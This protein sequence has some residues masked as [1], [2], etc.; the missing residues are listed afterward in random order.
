[1]QSVKYRI[2]FVNEEMH[3]RGVVYICANTYMNAIAEFRSRY[4]R[5]FKIVEVAKVFEGDWSNM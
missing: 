3:E 5:D 1:M 4:D 2:E